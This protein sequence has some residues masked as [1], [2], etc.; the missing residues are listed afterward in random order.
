MKLESK[1]V[2]PYVLYGA[3][4]LTKKNLLDKKDRIWTLQPSNFP[5][6]WENEFNSKI[7][8]RPMSMLEY[9]FELN[10]KKVIPNEVIGN[11]NNNFY[12]SGGLILEQREE[13]TV[14]YNEYG[15]YPYWLI[16]LL[17]EWQ[18]DYQNLIGQGLAVD[19]NTLK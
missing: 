8:L 6:N 9:S 11:L 13:Y 1:H 19:I 15:G 5:N 10:G 16:E 3:K 4:M 7:I 2:L 12:F 18:I 17:N 14:K